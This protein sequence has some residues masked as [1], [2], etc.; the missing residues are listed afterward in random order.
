MEIKE[1][2]DM[3]RK[4]PSTVVARGQVKDFTGGALSGKTVA[5]F[6][7]QGTGPAGRFKLGRSTV[8]PLDSLVSWLETRAKA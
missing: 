1:L 3:A 5:N 7:S 6:D 4:W 8:Y 2:R